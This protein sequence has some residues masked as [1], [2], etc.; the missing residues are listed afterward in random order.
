MTAFAY[1][2]PKAA[3]PQFATK[4][5]D[6]IDITVQFAHLSEPVRFTAAASDPGWEHSEEIYRRAKAGEFGKVLPFRRD[7]GSEW[8][9]LRQERNARLA[10][11]DWT[12]QPDAPVDRE[13][14]A[15]YRQALRD[16]PSSLEDP[17]DVEWPEL[18]A[19][20]SQS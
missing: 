19:F 13:G 15:R 5:K 18:G 8:N 17:A 4:E 3:R 6:K 2:I 9:A 7:R 12:Q 14:Y 16:L 20:I 1:T 10:A 11:T